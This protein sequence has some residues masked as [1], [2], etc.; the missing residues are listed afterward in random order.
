MKLEDFL[1][2][3]SKDIKDI[4]IQ[5]TKTNGRVSSLEEYKKNEIEPVVK[6]FNNWRAVK[7]YTLKQKAF[8]WSLACAFGVALIT[9]F[10]RGG[11]WAFEKSIGDIVDRNNS[12]LVEKIEELNIKLNDLEFNIN[13]EDF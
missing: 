8:R 5:T 6:E 1:M 13:I 3:M 4:R 12:G 9:A 11:I 2:E 7:K 10:W